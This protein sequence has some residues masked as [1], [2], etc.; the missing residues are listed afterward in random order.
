MVHQHLLLVP[1][2]TVAE[3]LALGQGAGWSPRSELSKTRRAARD[4]ADTYG[5]TVDLDAR[6]D[7]LPLGARQRVEILRLVLSGAR[8]LIF[9][10]PTA[11]LAPAEVDQL[12]GLIRRIAQEG[13]SVI[14]ISH[15][16]EE[17]RAVAQRCTVLRRGRVIDTVETS[18]ASSASLA[19]MMIGRSVGMHASRSLVQAGSERLAVRDLSAPALTGRPLRDVSFGVRSGEILGIAGVDGNGQEEL[20]AAIVGTLPIDGGTISLDGVPVTGLTPKR[21]NHLGGAVIYADR[22]RDAIALDLSVSDNMIASRVA[23]REFSR[24]G[25]IKRRVVVRW[26]NELLMAFG[27]KLRNVSLRVRQLSGGNQQR[28][29]LAR[30][31]SRQ[32][33]V[34]IAAQPTRGLDVGGVEF[35]Y[36]QLNAQ[37]RAGVAILLISAELDEIL[38]LSDQVAV[39]FNGELTSAADI[40]ETSRAE[41]GLLMSGAKAISVP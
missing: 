13:N 28:L 15:K 37:K 8:I 33:K 17:V 41:I 25:W 3:N 26:C 10:E 14:L 38:S 22:H 20:V 1:T 40:T 21:F 16:L 18:S 31:L 7:T 9:D 12:L 36:E 2:M 11:I 27:V 29:V 32:P 24:S 30:E 19:R 39:L 23:S 4:L 34:L 5:L 6:I 35:V